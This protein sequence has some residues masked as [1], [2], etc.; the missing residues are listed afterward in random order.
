MGICHTLNT[1]SNKVCAPNK[2]ED[3]NLGLFN[4][5]KGLN[6]SKTLTK[7]ILYECKCIF[8]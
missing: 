8:D 4:T 1:V 3:V 7:D 6:E 2:T 5:I